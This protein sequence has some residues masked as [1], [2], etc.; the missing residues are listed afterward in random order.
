MGGGGDE[1]GLPPLVFG[2]GPDGPAGKD[3]AEGHQDGHAQGHQG[4]KRETQ[5]NN[6]PVR[7]RH[8]PQEGEAE[9]A[10]VGGN[11]DHGGQV[12]LPAVPRHG[13]GGGAGG[14]NDRERRTA[15]VHAQGEGLGLDPL[16]EGGP[17]GGGRPGAGILEG[18]P[19]VG[20]GDNQAVRRL[21]LG[22]PGDGEDAVCLELGDDGADIALEGGLS[23]AAQL[24]LGDGEGHQCHSHQ[25][26]PREGGGEQG[27]PDA[28]APKGIGLSAPLQQGGTSNRYPTPRAVT[29]L[30]ALPVA[31]SRR[32]RKWM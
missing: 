18:P 17:A 29:I 30:T 23:A 15:G 14:L 24:P 8:I 20:D 16:Y 25:H 12:A 5:Q 19:C 6:L 26:R 32:R 28:Q 2:D 21:G 9:P 1:L 11:Q 3:P 10:V 22:Q 13:E 27:Q 31:A 7:R 4:D